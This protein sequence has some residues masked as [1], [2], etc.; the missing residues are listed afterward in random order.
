LAWA[1]GCCGVGASTTTFSISVDLRYSA[2]SH[3]RSKLLNA[4]PHKTWV[5]VF[6][7]GDDPVSLLADFAAEYKIGSAHISGIGGFS[8]VTLAFFDLKE[9]QYKPIPI[10]EQVEVMSLLGNIALYEG[11]SRMH[12][13]C[14]VGKRDGSTMGGHLLEA[15]VRPTLEV[16]VTAYAEPMFRTLDPGTNLPFLKP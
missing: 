15:H 7:P 3:M 12:L 1:H 9:K 6:D 11:K 4:E 14:I 16:F 2:A 8:D 13:H 10:R 5:V